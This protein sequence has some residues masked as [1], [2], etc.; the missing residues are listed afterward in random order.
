MK[1]SRLSFIDITRAFAILLIVFGHVI[2]H[3]FNTYWL[4]N[5]IYS[6]H[7]VLFF[8]ISGYLYNREK[9]DKEFIIKKFLTLIIPYF[10][11]AFVFFIR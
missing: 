6:F 10:I 11:F 3:N 5:I 9:S 4:F 8:I 1:T 7:V 2:V